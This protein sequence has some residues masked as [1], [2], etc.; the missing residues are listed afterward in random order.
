[1]SWGSITYPIRLTLQTGKQRKIS[2]KD[3]LKKSYNHMELL[4]CPISNNLYWLWNKHIFVLIE[5]SIRPQSP[6][7]CIDLHFTSNALQ[8]SPGFWDVHVKHSANVHRKLIVL[9]FAGFRLKSYRA[10]NQQLC[11][12]KNI[13]LGAQLR[14]FDCLHW[15]ATSTET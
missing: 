5:I 2:L 9:Q 10:W 8:H 6:L 12:N 11:N 1:M 7:G 3:I 13:G 14:I 15:E 4:N